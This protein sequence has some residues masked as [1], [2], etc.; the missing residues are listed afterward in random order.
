MT[1]FLQVTKDVTVESLHVYWGL[2]K[3]MA[4]VMIIVEIGIRF[5]IVDIIS[6]WCEPVMS[7]VG[8]PA[9]TALVLATNLLVGIYGAG[10]ALVTLSGDISLTVAN[11]TVLG[12]MLL[13]AH[14][15][16]IEQTLVKKTGV[17]VIFSTAVRL[18]AAML[19]A[20]ICHLIF[21]T[22][23]IFGDP[24]N[25]LIAAGADSSDG[26]WLEWI[27]SSALGLF[28]VFWILFFL[29]SMLRI[30]DATGLTRLITRMLTPGLKFLGIGPNAAP[31]AMI[32]IMLGLA[33]G[34]GLI[35]REIKKGG[36]KPKSIFISMIFMCFCHSL[37]EDTLIIMAF[38]GHWSGV[39]VGRVL[40]SFLMILPVSY[41]VLRMSDVTFYR[42]LFTKP[43]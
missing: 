40:I 18:L 7:L 4:P 26:S 31:L 20:W 24:A 41:A 21:S 29:I 43:K 16:P 28:W 32:G 9:E 23:D 27:K 2:L 10:A 30:M 42:Y 6:K 25:I 1:R 14:S 39:L 37:I 12:G 19:Y 8:L 36:L 11:M 3:I 33:F 38:G 34:G 35:I 13:F 17:S 22:F 5:G 15:L